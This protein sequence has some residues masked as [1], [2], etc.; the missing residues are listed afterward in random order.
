M[1]HDH[2]KILGNLSSYFVVG[3]I[4]YQFPLC[5]LCLPVISYMELI[6]PNAVDV[7]LNAGSMIIFVQGIVT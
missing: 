3:R 6:L 2:D 5:M 4:M 1:L 7:A